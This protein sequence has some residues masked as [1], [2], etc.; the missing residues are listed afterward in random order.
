MT[1]LCATRIA[2]F[3][4]VWTQAELPETKKVEDNLLNSLKS[5]VEGN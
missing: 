1:R 5:F 2:C 4:K 3:C